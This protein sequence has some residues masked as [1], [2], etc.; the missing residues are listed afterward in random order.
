MTSAGVLL[1]NVLQKNISALVRSHTRTH[2]AWRIPGE[3][4]VR[5]TRD[6]SG[7]VDSLVDEDPSLDLYRP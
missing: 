3:I 2:G 7:A 4:S 6:D 5:D 1:W